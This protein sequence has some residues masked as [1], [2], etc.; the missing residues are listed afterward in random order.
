MHGTARR[1]LVAFVLFGVVTT[2]TPA[3]AVH[4]VDGF[5][6]YS[7]GSYVKAGPSGTVI[8]AYATQARANSQFRLVADRVVNDERLP[9][10]R[11]TSVTL[12]PNVR[13]SNSSGTIGNTSGAINLPPGD[14]WVCFIEAFAGNDSGTA[15]VFFTVT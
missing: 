10:G 9:C 4:V 1:L 14:Y 12:N 7:D 11:T 2:A 8:T 3:G 15:P 5:T 6:W 13:A